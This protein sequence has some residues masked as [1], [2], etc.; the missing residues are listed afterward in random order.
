M[1]EPKRQHY[2]PRFYLAGFCRQGGRLWLRDGEKR[3]TRS[4]R[5]EN[6][7]VI[8]HYYSVEK[9]GQRDNT[10]EKGFA[11]LEGSTMPLIAALAAGE[12]LKQESKDNLSLYAAFQW[13]RVPDFQRGV[14][15][16][17]EHFVRKTMNMMF[18]DVEDIKKSLEEFTAKTG[19][20]VDV[21]PAK[22]L[23]MFQNDG[24]KVDIK[25]RL[26][27]EM[28]LKQ[29][30]PMANYFR[31][32]NWVILHAEGAC[33]F[34]TSDN[35]LILVPPENFP[36]NSWRGCGII[37]PGCRKILPLTDSCCL[38]MLDRGDLIVHHKANRMDI[39][40]I[41]RNI[42]GHVSRFLFARDEALINNLGPL[43]DEAAQNRDG[44]LTIN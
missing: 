26:S 19:E 21:N 40:N 44:R 17:G 43:A 5:P 39:R 34:V 38:M 23:D 37:T 15:K 11:E 9:D 14:D 32:M 33:S 8:N 13:M 20:V 2:V 4:D 30:E 1:S 6:V 29:A 24:I 3:Q 10:I 25:R 22:L 42:A 28:M 16:I 41:N 7:A 18:Q 35:P 36:R 12:Q 27:L 31:Q